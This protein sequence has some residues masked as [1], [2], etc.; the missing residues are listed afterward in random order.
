MWG[1]YGSKHSVV[2]YYPKPIYN[3]IIEP[4]A[5]TAPYSLMYWQNDITLVDKYDVIINIWKWLQQCSTSDIKSL[6]TI[7]YG[8]TVDDYSFDCEE[9][10]NLMG[11]LITASPS[12]PKKTPSRWKTIERPNTQNYKLNY[13][14]NN[15]YKIK[16]WN[17]ILGDYHDIENQE[18]T[19]FIDPPYQVGGEYYKYNNNSIDYDDLRNY[20]VSRKGQVIVCG[21]NNDTWLDFKPLIKYRGSC[22]TTVE[23]MWYKD[24]NGIYLPNMVNRK[25]LF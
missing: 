3:K 2:K 17:I 10:R 14:A 6:P 21:N 15:L 8:K 24:N 23:C 4:F 19:W 7:E 13:I 25:K 5:G 12:S 16:H 22:K 1:Y 11:F 9:A 20:C 18:A